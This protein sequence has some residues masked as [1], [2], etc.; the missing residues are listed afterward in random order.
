MLVIILTAVF[1]CT[2]QDAER[3]KL[4]EKLDEEFEKETEELLKVSNEMSAELRSLAKEHKDMDAKHLAF[5][6]EL[7]GKNLQPEDLAIEKTHREKEE[8]HKQLIQQTEK[9]VEL[10]MKRRAEHEKMEEGHASATPEQITEEHERFEKD[11]KELKK[12]MYIYKAKMKTAR[13]EMT[14]IFEEHEKLRQRYISGK[15]EQ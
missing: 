3:A 13:K 2:N 7:A 4:R 12:N 1:G 8:L 14:T 10:F 5:E 11:I 9:L 6:K 15:K